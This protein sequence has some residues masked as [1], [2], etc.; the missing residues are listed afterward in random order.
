MIS[1]TIQMTFQKVSRSIG[2]LVRK[3]LNKKIN[4]VLIKI[5]VNK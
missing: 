3:W 4:Y 5:E 2:N 1:Y